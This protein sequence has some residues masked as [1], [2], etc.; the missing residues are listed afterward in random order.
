[1]CLCVF[2]SGMGAAMRRWNVRGTDVRFIY[3]W[4]IL[5]FFFVEKNKDFFQ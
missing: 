2:L 1:M 3:E 4:G 5:D